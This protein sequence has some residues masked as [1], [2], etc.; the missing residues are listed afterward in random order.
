MSIN[1]RTFVIVGLMAI[2]ALIVVNQINRMTG[3]VLKP[4]TDMAKLQ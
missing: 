3:G 2:G 4:V 1:L